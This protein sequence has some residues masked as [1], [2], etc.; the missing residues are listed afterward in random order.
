MTD[1][2]DLP[3]YGVPAIAKEL[4]LFDENGAPDTRRCYYM[5]ER[6]YVDASKL[7]RIWTSTPRRLLGPH[8]GHLKQNTAT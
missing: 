3:V 7:G 6:G 8:L 4:N 1:H 5:L 2:L